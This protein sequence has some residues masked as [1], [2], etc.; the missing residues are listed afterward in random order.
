MKLL[1][2]PRNVAPL[3]SLLVVFSMLL[4]IPLG[5]TLAAHTQLRSGVD[6]FA[7]PGGN[8]SME[9]TLRAANSSYPSHIGWTVCPLRDFQ[10]V[11]NPDCPVTV[12]PDAVAFDPVDGE[13]DVAEYTS[14][15][16]SVVS[17]SSG[18]VPGNSTSTSSTYTV[19]FQE[20]GL[21]AGTTWA[22]ALN[23]TTSSSN[24]S[25]INFSHLANNTTGYAFS[26]TTAAGYMAS[27]ATGTVAVNGAN[28]TQN[29]TFQQYRGPTILGFN[30]TPNPVGVGHTTTLG[31]FATGLLGTFVYTYTGLPPGCATADFSSLLCTPTGAGD[32]TVR[33]FVNYTGGG[34]SN[35]TLL[36]IVQPPV[37]TVGFLVQ[38]SVCSPLTFNGTPQANHSSA[39]FPAGTYPATAPGCAGYGFSYW[40]VS[41]GLS[42]SGNMTSKINV[43]VA[44]NGTLS[45]VYTVLNLVPL[46]AFG[47]VT[48]V[49][50]LGSCTAGFSGGNV[51]FSGSASGGTPPYVFSWSFGDGSPNQTGQDVS[52]TYGQVG[53]WRANLTVTDSQGVQ[54]VKSVPVG[55]LPPPCTTPA[56]SSPWLLAGLL[57]IVVVEVVIVVLIVKKRRKSR[58]EEA[59]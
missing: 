39:T 34:S 12:S 33:V 19:G 21:P 6:T 35:A 42:L 56:N 2:H 43:T 44:G 50:L 23:G 54:A 46:Q 15:N 31:V 25:R 24:T 3:G 17:P 9:T 13:L 59:P 41:G 4:G 49:K 22:V 57:V 37:Y 40:K 53:A 32:F 5:I 28:V 7:T 30:A 27:P 58:R 10:L 51:S 48:S 45:D 18:R 36:L 8:V 26:V 1:A 52:H 20:S 16:V 14:N 55:L 47:T 38:P 29:I 11:G